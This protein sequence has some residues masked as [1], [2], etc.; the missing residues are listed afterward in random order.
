M[1]TL[2]DASIQL[3]ETTKKLGTQGNGPTLQ[4]GIALIDQ[5]ANSLQEI[6]MAQPLAKTLTTL[7]S[8]LQQ[9]PTDKETIQ[10]TVGKLAGQI[11]ELSSEMG[12]EGEMPSLLEG[13]ASTLRQ[14]GEVSKTDTSTP[15]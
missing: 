10:E 6:E 12:A 11:S 3:D 8:H 9:S 5:W 7:K 4:E 14:L 15:E 1:M 13:L 2:A